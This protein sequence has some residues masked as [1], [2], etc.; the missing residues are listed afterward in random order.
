MLFLDI[1][2]I[3]V[4]T[5]KEPITQTHELQKSANH[6]KSLKYNGNRTEILEQNFR[7]PNH[8][9]TWLIES[10]YFQRK[11][12]DLCKLFSLHLSNVHRMAAMLEVYLDPMWNFSTNID[13]NFYWNQLS[14]KSY[15][16]SNILIIQ[17]EMRK[18]PSWMDKPI[19]L[20][21]IVENWK[22]F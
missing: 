15:P 3:I 16:N 7:C 17:N 5:I 2:I 10:I 9:S 14:I 11:R 19:H 1:L 18:L 22:C 21:D 6:F 12:L 13:P 20:I 8:T 4:I